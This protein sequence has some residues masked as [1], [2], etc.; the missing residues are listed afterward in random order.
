MQHVGFRAP[1]GVEL[2]GH[3]RVPVGSGG[4]WPVVLLSNAMTSVKEQSVQSGYAHGLARAGFLT[5]TFDQ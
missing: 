2:V 4:P 3:L 5:L 1:D